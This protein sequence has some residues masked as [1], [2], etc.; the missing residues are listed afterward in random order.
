MS[1]RRR[2]WLFLAFAWAALMVLGSWYPFD[3]KTG[4]L[5]EAWADWSHVT[6]WSQQS[7]SDLAINMMLGI[8]LGFLL[9]LVGGASPLAPS[10]SPRYHRNSISVIIAVCLVAAVSLFVELGQHWYGRRVPSRND[11]ISQLLGGLVGGLLAYGGGSWFSSRVARFWSGRSHQSPFKALL[12]LYVAGYLLWAWMPFIPAVSPS[13]LKAKWRS[14]M[15]Q[16]SPFENWHTDTWQSLYTAAVTIATALPIGVWFAYW[17][18]TDGRNPPQRTRVHWIQSAMFAVGGVVCLEACQAFI[19]TR[20]AAVDDAI[21]SAV[22]AGVGACWAGRMWS[23]D[24]PFPLRSWATAPV[25]LIVAILYSLGYLLV[26]WAPFDFADSGLEMKQR[27]DQFRSIAMTNWFS[28][29]DMAMASNLLRSLW[30]SMLLGSLAGMSAAFAA[31]SRLKRITV[32]RWLAAV[33]FCVSV[34][35]LAEGGQI[36][37]RSR[38]PSLIELAVRIV[39]VAIGMAIAIAIARSET[40]G[41]LQI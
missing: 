36:F 12:D 41:D 1:V 31:P 33:V 16:L 35:L 10:Q 15:I 29:N 11:T 4:S 5:A 3:L 6:D 40:R 34:C 20:T 27:F 7:R 2:Y 32:L 30:F 22:G 13:E 28:G 24:S 14:G 25:L 21:G 17:S 19:E 8:P 39:G 18:G 9:V 23:S 38:S 37:E 26:S